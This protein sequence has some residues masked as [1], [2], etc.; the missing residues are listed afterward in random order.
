MDKITEKFYPRYVLNY[1]HMQ[2]LINF[3][4]LLDTMTLLCIY[5]ILLKDNYVSLS[6]KKYLIFN[7]KFFI[8]SWLK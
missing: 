1:L 5:S 7:K 3:Y 4:Y 8:C 2:R 6:N